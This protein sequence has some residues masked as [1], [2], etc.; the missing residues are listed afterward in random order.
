MALHAMVY[1]VYRGRS[2]M[3]FANSLQLLNLGI[4]PVAAFFAAPRDAA[5]V[6]M[7]TAAVW[8]I[9]SSIALIHLV[10]RER[11]E[12]K[13][14]A[15]LRDHLRTLLRF[16]LPRVPGEFA[17]VGLFAIPSLIAVHKEGVV[18][19]GQFSAALSIL[20]LASGVFSP[21]GLVI[22]PRASAQAASG[23]IAG[24]RKLVLRML[25]GGIL[26]AGIGVAI[27]EVL[28]PP[29]IRWYFGAAFVPAVP[30]FRAC[31]LG[32][33]PYAVYVLM[34]NILD[35]LEVKALNS[36]NLVI[37]LAVVI[38]LCLANSSIIWMSFS[39][40]GSL[41]LLGALTLRDTYMRLRIVPP[42]ATEAIPA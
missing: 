28:L 32:A 21:V 18:V 1:A 25:A 3:A 10:V 2:E 34:R 5:A 36:R 12:W 39:L 24:V 4:V 9:T 11:A 23:D 14:L 20:T 16:G 22:L 33:V 41:A 38:A 6:I 42:P 17:L 40:V 26:L 8:V 31:L 29:F 35:A 7:L 27:G 30:V 13:G 19:A 37:S 15:H